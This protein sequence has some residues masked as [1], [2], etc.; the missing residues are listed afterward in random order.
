M[1]PAEF[2]KVE[3]LFHQALEF[4][5]GADREWFVRDRCP[6]PLASFLRG[7]LEADAA[8]PTPAAE[9]P[10]AM[11]CCGPYQAETL[12]GSG[13]MGLVYRASRSDGQFTQTV[14]LK[15]LRS[16]ARTESARGRFRAERQILAQLQHPHI[17]ALHDGGV[18]A[19][20]EPYLVMEYV[21]GE[22]LD[23]YC[24]QRRLPP[25]ERLTLFRQVL[26]AVEYAH[27]NFIVHGDLKPSNIL[28]TAEGCVKLLDFGTSRFLDEETHTTLAAAM[29]P[30]YASPEQ[31]RGE[32]LTTASDVFS[33]GLILYELLI[34]A[35]AFPSGAS[36]MSVMARAMEET[37]PTDPGSAITEG[38]AA[39]RGCSITQLREA[40]RGDV[41]S[42]L[43]KALAHD[44]GGRYRSVSDFAADLDRLQAG[45]PVLAR[46]QTLLYRTGKFVNR[47]RLPVAAVLAAG[48]ALAALAGY[49]YRQQ[50]Q[51]LEQGRRAQ[52][53]NRFL[54]RLFTSIDPLYGGQWNMTAAELVDKSV[55]R[56]ETMLANEPA[57]LAEFQ[58]T[59][60]ANYLQSHGSTSALA[61]AERSLANARR[62]G[63]FGIQAMALAHL[64]WQQSMAGQCQDA[65]R[66]VTE[67]IN[68][69]A[70]HSKSLRREWK[71]LVAISEAQVVDFCGGDSKTVRPHILE[72]VALARQIPDNSLQE[73]TPPLMTKTM[74]IGTAAEVL[75]C[76]EG[77]PF[78][79]E[80]LAMARGVEELRNVE[81]LV[82]S[83]EAR[84]LMSN[85]PDQA[86]AMLRRSVE[87]YTAIL[88]PRSAS[89]HAMQ[90]ILA[91][92]LAQ[93]GVHRQ[94][95]EE[96]RAAVTNLDQ[97][98]PLVWLYTRRLAAQAFM[99]AGDIND[100]LPLA[101]ELV[102]D[103]AGAF[104]GQICLFVADVE[105]G[106]TAA[107]EP[108]RAAAE[109][110]TAYLPAGSLWRIKI[111]RALR[112][113]S[114]H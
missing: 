70:V 41:A 91:Y 36:L 63:D 72:A 107:A 44:P 77:R 73:E 66:S 86:I 81:A 15:L 5:P 52:V 58:M 28:V 61:M 114:A 64:G 67:A 71:I 103:P 57:S 38:A 60:A 55:P 94:A 95:I 90:A 84:C 78:R 1:T 33:L 50:R 106:E 39:A 26:D 80:V 98:V 74:A 43:L 2:K 83:Y 69:A 65:L 45:R 62:S 104:T 27:R 97:S 54:T 85:H 82:L 87:L 31:L 25:A 102:S 111:E 34:G 32:R 22:P 19:E 59:V 9:T 13:G 11:P 68:L 40:V 17:A 14:A 75:G 109:K 6:E 3:P 56:A 99:T 96:A 20:G 46:R 51:A 101:R 47:H 30:K 12:L 76:D 53:T 21:G 49:A 42:I 7:L 4:P 35:P 113:A 100:A 105:Q 24:D 37:N 89:T 88:G 16:V 79:Q 18:S 92:T 48:I 93:S 110:A 10:A 112:K 8:Q 108:Y 23:R 29:T